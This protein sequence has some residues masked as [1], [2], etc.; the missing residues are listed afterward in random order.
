MK[1]IIVPVDFSDCSLNAVRYASVLAKLMEAQLLVVYAH[2]PKLE[3]SATPFWLPYAETLPLP[4][5]VHQQM[6]NV[7][8]MLVAKG[9]EAQTYIIEGGLNDVVIELAQKKHADLVV[10]GTDGINF[11]DRKSVV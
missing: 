8:E 5:I 9:I 1:K 10:M 11:A 6:N 7:K 3:I 2:T 4:K